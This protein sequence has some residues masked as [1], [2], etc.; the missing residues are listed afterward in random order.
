M[1]YNPHPNYAM[2]DHF[3]RDRLREIV[4]AHMID[5]IVETGLN[6]GQSTE[7][8]AGMAPRVIGIDIDPLCVSATRNRL[9]AAGVEELH[10]ELHVGDSPV[11]LREIMPRLPVNTLFFL[12]AHWQDP[13]PLPEEIGALHRGEGIILLHDIK[14]PNRDFGADGYNHKGS[15]QLFTYELIKE[16]LAAWSPQHRIEYMTEASGSYRGAA[17][18]YAQ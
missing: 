3:L 9:L 10:F 11:V 18:V 6:D 15:H 4:K 14:V 13:W 5:T 7:V 12:D 17:F 8:L 1:P 16:Y 2:D